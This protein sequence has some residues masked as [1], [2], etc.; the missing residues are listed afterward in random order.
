[1]YTYFADPA[2]KMYQYWVR[3]V[4]L[5]A[6]TCRIL[7]VLIQWYYHARAHTRTH[8]HIYIYVYTHTYIQ[9]GPQKVY[10]LYSLFYMSKCIHFL[11]HSVNISITLVGFLSQ[12]V[13]SVDGY[14]QVNNQF[15]F[16]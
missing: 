11:G 1:M 6:E 4:S 14:G 12:T 15:Y 5:R 2:H 16:L 13:S 9:S 3:M 7:T 10:T 8:T